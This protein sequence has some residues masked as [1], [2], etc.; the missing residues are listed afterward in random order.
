MFNREVAVKGIIGREKRT[1]GK[2]N[3]FVTVSIAI[4]GLLVIN[5]EFRTRFHC[6]HK[7]FHKSIPIIDEALLRFW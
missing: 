6:G 1:Q 7:I 4:N 3:R 5:C 2:H